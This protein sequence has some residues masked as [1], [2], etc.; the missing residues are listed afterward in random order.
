MNAQDTRAEVVGQ[1]RAS[2]AETY[3]SLTDFRFVKGYVS[4]FALRDMSYNFEWVRTLSPALKALDSGVVRTVDEAL[5][6]LRQETERRLLGNVDKCSSS[7]MF[8][9]AMA[10]QAR[11]VC[12]RLREQVIEWQRAIKRAETREAEAKAKAERDAKHQCVDHEAEYCSCGQDAVTCQI[13]GCRFC[14]SLATTFEIKEGRKTRAGNVCPEC[15]AQQPRR[16]NDSG[17]RLI[18]IKTVK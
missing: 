15:T 13:C 4:S 7:C 3:Q 6:S 1:M 12:H 14:G 2:L 5:E 8:S 11:G 18:E 9:N 10:E 16:F 17:V